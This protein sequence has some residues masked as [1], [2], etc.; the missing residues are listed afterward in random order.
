MKNNPNRFWIT[1]I[2][3]GWVFDFLF[4]KKPLGINF[5][6]FVTLCL[7][8]GILL[9]RADGLRCLASPQPDIR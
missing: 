6:I 3:L 4:W 9:L 8:T 7:A 5:A 1:V 2:L